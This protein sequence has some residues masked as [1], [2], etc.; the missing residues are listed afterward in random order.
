MIREGRVLGRKSWVISSLQSQYVLFSKYVFFVR[1]H[2]TLK[3]QNLG[4]NRGMRPRYSTIYFRPKLARGGQIFPR[5]RKLNVNNVLVIA[6]SSIPIKA[7]EHNSNRAELVYKS[8]RYYAIN[9]SMGVVCTANLY[10]G[11]AR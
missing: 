6:A 5:Q 8:S 11:K 9:G 10:R 7:I 1:I 3:N 4:S 2:A